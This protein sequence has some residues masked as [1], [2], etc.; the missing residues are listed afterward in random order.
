LY[1]FGP[2]GILP[3]MKNALLYLTHIWTPEIQSE[4]EKLYLMKGPDFPETWLLLDS[5][6]PG[7][8]EIAERYERC[9]LFDATEMMNL[10]YPHVEGSRLIDH[11]HFPLLDFYFKHPDFDFYW[12]VEYDVRFTGE[13]ETLFNAFKPFNHDLITSHIRRHAQEPLWHWWPH[14]LHPAKKIPEKNLLRSF[15]VIFRISNKA[16]Q[17]IHEAQI[18]GWR[19]LNESTFPTLL[20]N[21]G[22]TILDFG[23]DGE[24]VAPGFK[25]RF[26]TSYSTKSGHSLMGT[27]RFRPPRKKA[28]FRKNTIYHPIKPK[29]MLLSE[30]PLRQSIK[31]M[32][33]IARHIKWRLFLKNS[34]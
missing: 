33:E 24:F 30:L 23:G 31:T 13:W 32:R 28:G 9:H 19:G 21:N 12:F 34:R 22:F 20:Y 16:L 5:N 1:I 4:F 2:Y 18:D 27:L 10:P 25:N 3:A 6:T 7:S 11:A 15:N 26:Y 14:F 29:E 8:A 17:F